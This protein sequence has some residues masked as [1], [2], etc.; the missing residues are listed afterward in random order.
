M[1]ILT[2]ADYADTGQW[3]LLLHISSGGIKAYLENTIHDD[4]GPE[5]L[6]SSSWE[7]DG[8][9]LLKHIENAVYDHPRVL[10][11]FSTRIVVCASKTLLIPTT[12]LAD[13]EG[14]EEDYFTAVY[15]GE[16]E[17]VITDIDKE[18]TAAFVLVAGLKGFL[19]RT[20]PGA[21]VRSNLMEI[22]RNH[23]KTAK[24]AKMF[25]EIR[26]G[27]ADFVLGVDGRLLSG[28]THGW[29]TGE[30]ICYHAFNI[31]NV[32]GVNPAH[33]VVEIAGEDVSD[34]VREFIKSYTQSS[35][36]EEK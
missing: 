20:F 17:D 12:L 26:K 3:R 25:I 22:Y 27:E 36:N 33:T 16:P 14:A 5:V 7:K 28:S 32:Y 23:L 4:L 9:E 15:E 29:K 2:A 31:L 19:G 21:S 35:E 24:G 18:V 1:T 30:D 6:F 13:N 11:D 34:R 8:G 10:D